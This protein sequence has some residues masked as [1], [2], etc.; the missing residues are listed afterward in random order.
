MN[1]FDKSGI[2]TSIASKYGSVIWKGMQALHLYSLPIKKDK[3]ADVAS[4]AN[5]V[6]SLTGDLIIYSPTNPLHSPK[7]SIFCLF[8]Y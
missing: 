7:S 5:L 6:I 1:P 8:K 2:T 3:K 4:V